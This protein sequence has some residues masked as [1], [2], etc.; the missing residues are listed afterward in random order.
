[1]QFDLFSTPTPCPTLTTP[2]LSA[3]E[4]GHR[5]AEACAAKADTLA[6]GWTQRAAEYL[7]QYAHR[8]HRDDWWLMEDARAWC[9][10]GGL[11]RPHD[12][13]AWGAV[14]RRLKARLEQGPPRGAAS[15]HGSPKPTW[16]L[17]R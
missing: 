12:D 6:D 1:M 8:Q 14:L 5:A 4:R 13:R 17:A 15:S 10:A 7:T 9:Y 11:A 3:R 16:R 2:T